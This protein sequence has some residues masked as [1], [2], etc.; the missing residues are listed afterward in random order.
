MKLSKISRSFTKK[1]HT[2]S[3][4]KVG[5]KKP[6]VSVQM[7]KTP[8]NI[9]FKQ[10]F[11]TQIIKQQNVA[12]KNMM[13]ASMKPFKSSVPVKRTFSVSRPARNLNPGVL[14]LDLNGNA[15]GDGKSTFQKN[16]EFWNKNF[17]GLEKPK[18]ISIFEE[19]GK[20][21]QNT[22][23]VVQAGLMGTYASLF[24]LVFSPYEFVTVELAVEKGLQANLMT[25]TCI[26][27]ATATLYKLGGP[28]NNKAWELLTPALAPFVGGKPATPLDFEKSL[29]FNQPEWY[30]N[31]QDPKDQTIREK[32]VKSD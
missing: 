20:T 23:K 8:K 31:G 32:Y 15:S 27:A 25:G 14:S 26:L 3:L 18:S 22:Y 7:A 21:A 4:A 17:P 11:S 29:T 10:N 5:V 13:A 28:L 24:S 6:N 1:T 19:Y 16:Q 12:P 9:Q 2:P 30:T